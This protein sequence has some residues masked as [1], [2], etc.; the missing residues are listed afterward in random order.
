MAQLQRAFALGHPWCRGL[1]SKEKAQ[2]DIQK[3]THQFL[4]VLNDFYQNP[5]DYCVTKE[6]K[7]QYCPAFQVA[8]ELTKF[9]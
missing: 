2:G 4:P 3:K 6:N 7:I 9:S 8:K 5:E 1:R